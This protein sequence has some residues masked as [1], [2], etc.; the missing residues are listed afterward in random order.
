[1][2]TDLV[3]VKTDV[4]VLKKE[5]RLIWGALSLLVVTLAAIFIRLFTAWAAGGP[6]RAILRAG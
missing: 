4:A 1:M 3:T 2:K 5:V 6:T